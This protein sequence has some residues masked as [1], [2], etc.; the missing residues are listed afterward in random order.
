[1][2]RDW[3]LPEREATPESV[4]LSRREFLLRGSGALGAAATLSLPHPGRIAHAAESR[5]YPAK[6]NAALSVDLPLT[7]EA[8]AA[9]Y[10]N[11]YEFG[12]DKRISDRAQA[13]VLDPWSIEIG[14]LVERPTTIAFEDLERRFSL[15]E[16]IYRFRCVEAWA[17]VVPWTGFRLA[18]LLDWVGVKPEARYVR[19]E[20]FHRPRQA[21][22]QLLTF[23]YSWP[24]TEG[25]TL[26]EARNDL[27]MLV[28]G[29]YGKPLPKQHGAPLRLIVPW[30][31]GFKSLKSIVRID[32]V[33]ARPKTFWNTAA[34]DEYGFFA[35]VDPLVP[36]PRWSQA[37]EKLLGSDERQSTLPYNGYGKWV[38]DLYRDLREA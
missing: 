6:R 34:P 36:H 12:T 26:A 18:A 24:Y 14:G 16:R 25:L 15:E 35:N 19:L 17:M 3:D 10:N 8:L 11:F 21:L 5:P 4:F 13:L 1:M 31:Y 20:S 30:K 2:D 7:D 37:T 33:E 9:T 38:A 28:T 27:A 29:V 32:L 22:G 23:W